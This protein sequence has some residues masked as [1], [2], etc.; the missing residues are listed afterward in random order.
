MLAPSSQGFKKTTGRWPSPG[1][2]DAS[3]RGDAGGARPGALGDRGLG[4]R[5]RGVEGRR[6]EAKGRKEV[7]ETEDFGGFLGG[8]RD[9]TF[10]FWGGVS[11]DWDFFG[12]EGKEFGL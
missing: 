11:H 7:I 1:G 10:F 4:R 5:P 12:G 3:A 2:L 6:N 9:E 8:K